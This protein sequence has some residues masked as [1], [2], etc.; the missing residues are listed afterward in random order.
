MKTN[1]SKIFLFN[2]LIWCEDIALTRLQYLKEGYT[3]ICTINSAKIGIFVCEKD[4]TQ[5][6]FVRAGSQLPIFHLNSA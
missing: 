1:D 5:K 4:S 3:E 2:C 6:I